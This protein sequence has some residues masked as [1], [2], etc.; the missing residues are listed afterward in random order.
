MARVSTD[1][2]ANPT[3][4]GFQCATCGKWHDTLPLDVGFDEPL[5][6]AELSESDRAQRVTSDDGDFRVVRKAD[7]T[8]YFVRG[9]VEVPVIGTGDTFCFGAWATLSAASYEQA[10]AAYRANGAAGPFFGWPPTASPG[11]RRRCT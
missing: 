6:V 4:P 10:R 8:H 1:R 9:V 11:T 5:H 3:A 7:G 2:P